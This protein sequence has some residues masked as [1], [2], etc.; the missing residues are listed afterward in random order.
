MC[1]S[2]CAPGVLR[3]GLIGVAFRIGFRTACGGSA[4]Q[5]SCLDGVGTVWH[6]SPAA[7]TFAGDCLQEDNNVTRRQAE[8]DAMRFQQSLDLT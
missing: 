3:A 8:V 4:T 2:R 5:F 6:Q 1:P 7:P